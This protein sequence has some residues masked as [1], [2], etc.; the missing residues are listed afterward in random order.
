MMYGHVDQPHHW[1][2]HLRLLA[3]HPGPDRR[4]H[5][6]R[7]AAVRPHTTRRST[8]PASPARADPAARTGP[9][10]RWP[11]SCCTAGSTTSSAPGSSS[12]RTAAAEMLQRRRQRPRRHADGGD[13]LAGWPARSTAPA[14]R[15][16]SSTRSP[17]R[18]AARPGS[19]PRLYGE[20][21][22]NARPPTR[23]GLSQLPGWCLVAQQHQYT[24]QERTRQ[25]GNAGHAGCRSPPHWRPAPR[26]HGRR[27]ALPR[28]GSRPEGGRCRRLIP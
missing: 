14:S 1:V 20:S 19:A 24:N 13:H 16:R 10:T 21:P 9:C 27:L 28:E 25:R 12:A 6:V 7:A 3:A 5:R 22:A 17:P 4:V 8:W 15:S 11:G 18:P 2:A 26:R 23:T